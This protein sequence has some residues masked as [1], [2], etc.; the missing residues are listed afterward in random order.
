MLLHAHWGRINSCFRQYQE[1]QAHAYLAAECL[2]EEGGEDLIGDGHLSECIYCMYV[3][4]CICVCLCVVCV[5]VDECVWVLWGVTT[6][7]LPDHITRIRPC[8]S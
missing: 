5:H 4:V 2:L 7:H 6:T 8:I 3:C 1:G